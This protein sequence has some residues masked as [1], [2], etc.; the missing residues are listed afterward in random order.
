MKRREIM[1]FKHTGLIALMLGLAV[2]AFPVTQTDVATGLSGAIGI[3]AD[4]GGNAVYFVE[5]TGGRLWQ[6]DLA[7]GSKTTIISGLESPVGL[8]LK[9]DRTRAY[10]SEQAPTPKIS[11]IDVATHA[12]LGDVVS[13]GLTSPFFLRFTDP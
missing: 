9:A 7:S 12:R 13:S 11:A 5:F 4:P 10:V 1:Q 2:P 6:I 8:V 3:A